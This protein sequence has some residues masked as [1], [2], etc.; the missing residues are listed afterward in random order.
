MTVQHIPL[1]RLVLRSNCLC[2]RLR[3]LRRVVTCGKR[4]WDMGPLF[5]LE[6]FR[7]GV[8]YKASFYVFLR[9]VLG[10]RDSGLVLWLKLRRRSNVAD[11]N[12][13]FQVTRGEGGLNAKCA[14][15][16]RCSKYVGITR[17]VK[18]GTVSSAVVTSTVSFSSAVSGCCALCFYKPT[19]GPLFKVDFFCFF[20]DFRVIVLIFLP[21]NWMIFLVG[22]TSNRDDAQTEELA[23]RDLRN[24]LIF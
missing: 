6:K 24:I 23:Y 16:F 8:V 12:S 13:V 2:S 1:P 18:L 5:A 19:T 9:H 7:T 22:R 11:G 4:I 17:A 10:P 20:R 3:S 14:I 15:P 21:K